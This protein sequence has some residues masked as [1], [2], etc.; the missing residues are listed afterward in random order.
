MTTFPLLRTGV[1][2]Q[3]P[4]VTGTQFATDVVQFID[5]TEQRFPR[6]AAP[7][8]TWT[9]NLSLLDEAELNSALLFFRA[10]RG[11]S[12]TFS[13]TDPVDGTVY[14]KCSFVSDSVQTSMDATGRCSTVVAIQQNAS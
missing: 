14:S 1:E 2:V 7:L 13:F 5:G 3:Y 6:Y 12:G 8:Q 10:N 9:V 4:L 11:I